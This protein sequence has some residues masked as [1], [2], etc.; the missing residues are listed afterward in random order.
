MGC[1]IAYKQMMFSSS[2]RYCFFCLLALTLST[3]GLWGEPGA[4]ALKIGSTGK[5][6]VPFLEEAQKLGHEIKGDVRSFPQE[7]GLFLVDLSAP[8]FRGADVVEGAEAFLKKGGGILFYFSRNGIPQTELEKVIPANLWT[9]QNDRLKRLNSGLLAPAGSP[10]ADIVAQAELK[11]PWRFDLHLPY[12]TMELG[13]QRYEWV[14]YGKPLWNTDWQVL[15]TTDQ[16]GHLPMLISGNV[17]A[18]RVLIFGGDVNAPELAGSKGYADFVKGLVKELSASPVANAVSIEGLKVKIP[19]VQ[20]GKALR[21]E[22]T[23]ETARSLKAVLYLKVRN[24]SRGLMNSYSQVV[25][26]PAGKTT[27]VAV[28]ENYPGLNSSL[29]PRESDS[30]GWRWVEV[31][32]SGLNRTKVEAQAEALVDLTPAVTGA[33]DGEDVRKFPEEDKWPAGGYEFMN[34]NGMNLSRYVYFCG[35]KPQIKVRLSNALH[36]IAPLAKALDKQ[37]PENPTTV[38]INDGAYSYASVRGKFP[39]FGYW[40]GKSASAQSVQLQW[41]GPVTIAGER[42]VA[43][44]NYRNWD[45]A[46]PRDYALIAGPGESIVKMS[47]AV[48]ES[49][50]R[51]DVFKPV[52]VTSVELQ[53]SGLDE[54]ANLEPRGLKDLKDIKV[55]TNCALAEWEVYGW[56]EAV[57]PKTI[58][59][60]LTVRLHDLSADTWTTLQEK[61]IEIAAASEWTQAVDIPTRTAF[62]QVVVV[63]V[64]QGEGISW[65][66]ER[67]FLFIPQG[68][69]HLLSRDG[70][71]EVSTGYLC[72]PGFVAVEE[73]GKGTSDDTQGWGGPDD[74]AWAWSLDLMEIGTRPTE[75]AQRLFTSPVGMTHYTSPWH[76]FP[77]GEYVWN[78]VSDRL[79]D[80]FTEGRFKGKT[81]IHLGLSDRWNGVPIGNTFS[82]SDLVAFDEYLRGQGK[83][84][85]KGRTRAQLNDEILSRYGDQYQRY[86][87]MTYAEALV[88]SQKRFADNGVKMTVETHGSFPLS[89]GELGEMLGRTHVSV[90]T[91]LFWE[92]K[93]EDL[94]KA[95]GYRFGL[96]ALNPDFKSGAYNQWG[97]IS[98]VQANPTWFSPSGDVEPSRRQWYSTYWSGRIDSTGAFLPL[99]IYGFSS[100]GGFGVKNTA[101]DW[102]AFNR[103]QSTTIWLRPEEPTGFGIVGSWQLQEKRMGPEVGRLFFGLSVAKGYPQTDELVGELYSRMV[104]NGVPVSFVASTHTLKKWKGNQPLIV[105]YGFELEPWE[106]AELDRLNQGGAP[107]IAVGSE[108]REGRTQAEEFFGVKKTTEG[109]QAAEG[110][111]VVNDADGKPLAFIRKRGKPGAILFCPGEIPALSSQQS[112][113]LAALALELCGNPFVVSQGV[114]ATAFR[115]N[116][117]LF[118]T[119]GE[120]GDSVRNLDVAIKPAFFDS[121][122]KGESYRVIDLDRGQILAARWQNGALH[123]Q[124]PCGANDGRL[125]QIISTPTQGQ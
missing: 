100:Q 50:L 93:D 62:G 47:E 78:W 111:E 17:Y 72:S 69:T 80:S 4:V 68:R 84:G 64:F 75:T 121:S 19:P 81:S 34:G 54:K 31:G 109:W 55:T 77:S 117:R 101:N 20:C 9:A 3:Q 45:K 48:F 119:L 106:I 42:L 112:R 13:Q 92:L 5:E 103:V 63:A 18:G 7:A 44:T 21:V 98:A 65:K 110:T 59:G 120:Q 37:W 76:R 87:L 85:L 89:G 97:W 15:L 49:G 74:K 28:T 11:L 94:Y 102:E 35:N 25:D 33:I 53:I 57:L 113:Q 23:N 86:H 16:E 46:N 41:P 2:S 56:P 29:A 8:T 95:L 32:L 70:L 114:A 67:P 96:L 71:A 43:Q 58:K 40:V 26:V 51:S 90:G 116:D 66:T 24:H 39:V 91:D 83:P 82:W 88:N 115:S 36:N 38:S 22:V 14:R 6:A 122:L 73:F 30:D 118:L 107:I 125:L 27:A 79:M 1:Y 12:S 61:N 104:K 60:K 105:T 52:T 10:L 108:G 124:V 123:F 99:T